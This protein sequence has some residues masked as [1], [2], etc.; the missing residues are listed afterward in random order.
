MKAP[1]RHQR[2][3]NPDRLSLVSA[4][5]LLAYALARFI[6]L[7]GLNLA[8]QLPGFYLAID[9]NVQTVVAFIV[10]GL[11]ATGMNWLVRDHP[12]LTRRGA[13]EHWLL[14]ALTASALGLPL[15]QLPLSPQ[16][17]LGFA[18]GGALL[19]LVLVAE[20]IVVDPQDDRR[21]PAAA[22]LTALSFAL[23]LVLAA[24]LR[25]AGLRLFLLLPAL[26]LAA[27]LVSLRTLRLRRPDRWSPVEAGVIAL[28]TVQI[29]AALH[30]WPIPPVPFGLALLGP[31]YA[32]T[33]LISNLSEGE[34][35]RQAALEPAVVLAIIWGAAVW[36]L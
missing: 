33:T 3:P 1:L 34:P 19:I 5:I 32:I 30:Y 10:A 17:W 7:P 8:T 25:F 13:P 11:T 14:P 27:G 6:Q 31:T 36:M 23:F 35:P 9:L 16:W 18:L 21:G 4:T 20:Y 15:F 24:G 2:L 26:G 12:A 22:G 28:V 29:G